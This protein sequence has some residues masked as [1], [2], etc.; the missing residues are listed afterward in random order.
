MLAYQRVADIAIENDP[1]S[2]LIYLLNMDIF[3]IAK[4]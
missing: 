4:Y 1:F 2:S 3:S